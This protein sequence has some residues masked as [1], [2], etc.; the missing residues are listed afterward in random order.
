M[1]K[2]KVKRL[3]SLERTEIGDQNHVSWYEEYD[4]EEINQPT[5]VAETTTE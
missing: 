4:D 3:I 2:R 5:V 1:T